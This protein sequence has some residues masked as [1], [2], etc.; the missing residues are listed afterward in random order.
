VWVPV[1]ENVRQ[2]KELYVSGGTSGFEAAGLE[3]SL[4][5]TKI[6]SGTVIDRI[7]AYRNPLDILKILGLENH[8]KK[9]CKASIAINMRST[10]IG[11]KHIIKIEDARPTMNFCLLGLLNAKVPIRVNFIHNYKVVY[12]E[13][14][15]RPDCFEGVVSCENDMCI[16]NHGEP[17]TPRFKS[18]DFGG[19]MVYK[20]DYCGR[21]QDGDM[22]DRVRPE[23]TSEMPPWFQSALISPYA[24]K[25]KMPLLRDR[26]EHMRGFICCDPIR[27]DN[28]D[29][30]FWKTHTGSSD[31]YLTPISNIPLYIRKIIEAEQEDL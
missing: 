6:E 22:L 12:K 21:F 25:M 26:Y 11:R 9:G 13:I 4:Y 15:E 19:G 17:V 23:I 20:C 10:S 24:I 29:I 3:E 14:V 2:P 5:V 8:L 28:K 16:T 31:V 7:P 1:T 18:I 27:L 30:A